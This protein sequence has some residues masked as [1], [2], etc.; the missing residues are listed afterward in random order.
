MYKLFFVFAIMCA[1]IFYQKQ[2]DHP[3][4]N[5]P[6]EIDTI[7][8]PIP[9][10]FT[11]RVLLKQSIIKWTY[12]GIIQKDSTIIDYKYVNRKFLI[13]RAWNFI[14]G[15]QKYLRD[16]SERIYEISTPSQN[17]VMATSKV[18]NESADSRKVNYV[19]TK[20]VTTSYTISDSV[21][22]KYDG[23]RI[24]KTSNHV[25]TAVESLLSKLFLAGVR[26]NTKSN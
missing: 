11:N 21:V 2:I 13:S 25:N 1:I 17:G 24:V 6:E 7:S 16:S 18:Y 14:S 3:L 26:T 20:T 8:L 22:F 5:T 9:A 23:D 15:E 19:V 4:I 10:S 12:G